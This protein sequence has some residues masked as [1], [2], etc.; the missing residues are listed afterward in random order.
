MEKLVDSYAKKDL[1]VV[2][3]L[4]FYEIHIMPMVNPDG[5]QYSIEVDRMWRKNRSPSNLFGCSGVD[6][7]RNFGF[8]WLTSGSSNYE[9]SPVYAVKIFFF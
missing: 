7:N 9:C 6:L 2:K 3:L 1:D 5:Y 4:D 8:Y